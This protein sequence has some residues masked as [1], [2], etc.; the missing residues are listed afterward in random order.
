MSSFLV[1][2]SYLEALVSECPSVKMEYRT[3]KDHNEL[4]S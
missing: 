3:K 1:D 2:I 4:S